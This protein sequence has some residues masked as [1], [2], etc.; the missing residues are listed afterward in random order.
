MAFQMGFIIILGTLLGQWLDTK[1]ATER[2]WFTMLCTFV[3]LILA[4][5]YTIKDLI[6]K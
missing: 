2:P 1:Y 3:A 6:R 5:Y 4:F